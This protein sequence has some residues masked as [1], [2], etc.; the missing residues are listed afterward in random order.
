[1]THAFNLSRVRQSKYQSACKPGSVPWIVAQGDD[2]SSGPCVAAWFSRPTR[3]RSHGRA[4]PR[5][6]GHRI[7]IRSCS[8]RG[9]P[10]RLPYGW[11]GGLLPHRFTLT[12]RRRGF[13]GR[14]VLCG[15]IPRITSGGHYPP[16]YPRGARTFLERSLSTLLRGLSEQART[17]G[18]PRPSSRLVGASIAP[19]SPRTG[20]CGFHHPARRRSG[21]GGSGAGTRSART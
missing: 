10:C 2:H 4:V 6:R 8:R 13:G 20:A 21:A 7:P 9:L 14:S 17:S 11:R 12:L 1:V 18:R 16:P 19:R 15:A 5:C 3:M